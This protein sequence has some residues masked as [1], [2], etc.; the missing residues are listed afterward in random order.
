MIKGTFKAMVLAIAVSLLAIGILGW[1]YRQLEKQRIPNLQAEIDKQKA[2]IEQKSAEIVL[3]KFMSV[4]IMGDAAQIGRYLTENA[5]KQIESEE[6]N[7][8]N[9][10]Q[11]YEVLNSRD[12][13]ENKFRFAVKVYYKEGQV[14]D[15]VELITLVKILDGYY[16]DFLEFAG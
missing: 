5:A 6:F 13:G 12:L 8:E 9:R 3:A 11:N 1:Q 15:L 2:E 7:L 10:V 4:R 14:G 16:I